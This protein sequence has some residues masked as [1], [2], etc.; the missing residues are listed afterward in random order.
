MFRK[1]DRPAFSAA[2]SGLFPIYFGMQTGLPV[3]MALTFPGNALLG[4][5]SSIPGLLEETNRYS[6]LLPLAAMFVFG[7][8]NLVVLLPKVN[9]VMQDRRGQGMFIPLP[10]FGVARSG[11]KAGMV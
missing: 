1:V 8:A 7:L 4:H 5:S 2:Q 10:S 9:K 3:V 6:S 11:M